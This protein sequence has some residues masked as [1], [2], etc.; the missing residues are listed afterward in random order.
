MTAF[1]T[2]ELTWLVI[3]GAAA[4]AHLIDASLAAIVGIAA[5]ELMRML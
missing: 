4:V 1:R 5:L 2:A 3:C